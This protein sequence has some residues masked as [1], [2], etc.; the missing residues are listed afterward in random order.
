MHAR[1]RENIG[2]IFP[3]AHDETHECEGYKT[4]EEVINKNIAS[5]RLDSRRS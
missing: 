3:R 5:Y 2:K 1:T 4:R